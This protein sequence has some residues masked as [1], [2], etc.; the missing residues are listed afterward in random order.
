MPNQP[1]RYRVVLDYI[2]RWLDEQDDATLRS[3]TQTFWC[4]RGKAQASVVRWS[5][6]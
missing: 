1:H 2:E 6:V 3:F 5:I 4:L